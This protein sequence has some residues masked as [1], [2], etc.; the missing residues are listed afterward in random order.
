ML[1]PHEP[2]LD[3]RVG[4]VTD[5]CR[6]LGRTEVV[7]A[8]WSS[9]GPSVEFDGV[10]SIDRV[11]VM[12]NASPLALRILPLAN[13]IGS[14]ATSVEYA[15]RHGVR[16]RSP[17]ARLRH[18]SGAVR[19][20]VASWASYALLVTAL[21]RRARVVGVKPD[22]IVAHDIYGL[23]PAVLLKR[24][25]DAKVLYDSHEYAAQGD[26]IGP[27]WQ[28]RLVR[29]VERY[30]IRRVE[31]V[32]TV[33]PPLARQLEADYRI[34]DVVSVPNAE[35]AASALGELRRREHDASFVRFLL[36]GQ[37]APGRG[38]E[39][40]F[41]L[42]RGL[43]NPRAQLQVRCP[44]GPYPEELRRRFA[45]LFASDTAVWLDPVS[46]S[47]MVSAAAEASVGVIPY[48]GPNLNHLYACPN[49]LSQYMAAGLAILSTDLRYVASII[50]LY[51][52]GAV[53]N[54]EDP[55][56]FR[57][58]IGL[59]VDD[60]ARLDAMRRHALE[61]AKTDYNWETVSVAYRDALQALLT[62]TG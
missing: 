3:P 39:R 53:Y 38:F 23:I 41:E 56:S 32:V 13:R 62:W 19:R 60:P 58:A 5:M 4:W 1:V 47:E 20:L 6:G 49:K 52:C 31:R 10:V 51:D 34:R 28:E 7:A 33:S 57:T 40:L 2:R 36:Q 61:A 15:A 50:S 9:S 27:R 55:A 24:R 8:V 43:E 48:L 46:E 35:P 42:W 14:H 18:E 59:L 45:D 44:D 11:P 37:A 22:V 25:W 30:F 29:H 26:L 17:R 21:Y 16:P 12:A 54:P